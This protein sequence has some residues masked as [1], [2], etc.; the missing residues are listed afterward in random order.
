MAT[1]K[2]LQRELEKQLKIIEG[3]KQ[4]IDAIEKDVNRLNCPDVYKIG[5]RVR[6]LKD[7]S[8]RDVG[9]GWRAYKHF[10]T[11]LNT[12]TVVDIEVYEERIAYVLRFDDQECLFESCALRKPDEPQ[13]YISDGCF[14]FG[15]KHIKK[16]S[17]PPRIFRQHEQNDNGL[18]FPVIHKRLKFETTAYAEEDQFYVRSKSPISYFS[19]GRQ[20]LYQSYTRKE[21]E[22]SWETHM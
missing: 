7:W 18:E 6:L 17:K 15:Q 8:V 3:A 13:G 16:V 10:M 22:N 4:K 11:Q 12:A 5:D 2:E 19:G 20:Y 9:S 14:V 1:A 21:F